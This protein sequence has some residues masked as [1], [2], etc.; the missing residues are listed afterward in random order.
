MWPAPPSVVL[1]KKHK[2]TDFCQ[3]KL[4]SIMYSSIV[5][6]GE[7]D[8][9]SL[10]FYLFLEII[11]ILPSCVATVFKLRHD[12]SEDNNQEIGVFRLT[13]PRPSHKSSQLFILRRYLTFNSPPRRSFTRGAQWLVWCRAQRQLCFAKLI[14]ILSSRR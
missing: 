2:K 1:C 4:A 6:T 3:Y 10:M 5:D 7:V 12:Q 13:V 8:R 14:K 9:I 11:F